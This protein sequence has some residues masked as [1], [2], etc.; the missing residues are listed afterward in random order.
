MTTASIA[1]ISLLEDPESRVTV[2]VICKPNLIFVPI[3]FGREL[4]LKFVSEISK[5]VDSRLHDRD[6]RSSKIRRKREVENAAVVEASE[7]PHIAIL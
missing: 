6:A 7:H 3:W 1:A 5:L 2:T 4:L